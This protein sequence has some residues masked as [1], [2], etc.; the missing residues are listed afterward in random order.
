MLPLISGLVAAALFAAAGGLGTL[1]TDMLY[2]SLTREDDGPASVAV[3][4][5]VFILAAAC[6]GFFVGIHG[7]SPVHIAILL[8]AVLSLTVCAATDFRAGLIPDLFSIG[9][10]VIV[11]AVSAVQRDWNPALGALFVFVPFAAMAFLSHG[12]GM[13]WGDVKLAMLGGALVGMAGI[14]LAVTVAGLCA[15]VVGRT[16]GRA[17]QPIA[18]GPY[19]AASIGAALA[20]GSTI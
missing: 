15:Y 14:T 20:V 1:V 13:G 3:P 5:W 7:E 11:L 18:F 9:P 16:G 2:G 4:P 12:R 10:L 17:R 6:I 19:L 8:I